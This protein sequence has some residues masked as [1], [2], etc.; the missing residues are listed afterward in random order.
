MRESCLSKKNSLTS[1]ELNTSSEGDIIINKKE[2]KNSVGSS[3]PEFSF[4]NINL[5]IKSI[6]EHETDLSFSSNSNEEIEEKKVDIDYLFDSKYWRASKETN[7]DTDEPN[8]TY[9][10]QTGKDT[11]SKKDNYIILDNKNSPKP[12]HSKYVEV[13]DSMGISDG[14]NKQSTQSNE[15]EE[16]NLIYCESNNNSL[17]NNESEENEKKEK[18][19][20]NI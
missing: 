8:S 10:S 19:K 20:I 16:T 18:I 1:N 11:P 4:N 12:F 15:D 5:E 2:R 7:S 14:S 17:G 3:S 13:G 6:L 9:E